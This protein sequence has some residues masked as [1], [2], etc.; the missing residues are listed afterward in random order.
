MKIKHYLRL[1][2]F[3]LVFVV[4][5]GFLKLANAESRIDRIDSSIFISSTVGGH[6][7]TLLAIPVKI[8]YFSNPDLMIGAEYASREFE[9]DDGNV[10]VENG[11]I[12]N[13]GV[14][15]RYFFSNSFSDSFNI[16]LGLNQR[17]FN[18]DVK[19][20]I[21]D[22]LNTPFGGEAKYTL[23]N[24]QTEASVA[25]IA[26]GNMWF[27]KNG[28]FV[29][30]DWIMPSYLISGSSESIV[31]TGNTQR[32]KLTSDELKRAEADLNDFGETV[33]KIASSNGYV[34]ISIGFAW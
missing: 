27:W 16:F 31:T 20:R 21:D 4:T 29:G 1:L 22:K 23:S 24:L 8:G 7:P 30:I 9:F 13:R 19:V 28:I 2:V 12:E 33:N 5:F 34:M 15:A 10:L 18:V 32:D 26:I 25:S 3:I 14:S 6:I 17:T 11:K